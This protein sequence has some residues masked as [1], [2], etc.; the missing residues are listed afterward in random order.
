ME[1][2]ESDQYGLFS[3]AKVLGLT[4]KRAKTLPKRQPKLVIALASAIDAEHEKTLSLWHRTGTVILL[5]DDVPNELRICDY[6]LKPPFDAVF[7]LRIACALGSVPIGSV[8]ETSKERM[9]KACLR[10]LSMPEHLLGFSYLVHSVLFLFQRPKEQ[11]SSMMYEIYPHLASYFGTTPVMADRA[12]RHA[13]E[14]SWNRCDPSVVSE[15]LGYD[16]NDK[17]GIP[18]NA[19][20][21]YMLYERIRLL[22]GEEQNGSQ[23]TEEETLVLVIDG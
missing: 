5:I 11:R 12:I 2:M 7:L 13:V 4:A 6:R 1:G 17:K 20:Y 23:S 18:T 16:R 15:Y 9:A 3:A 14:V 19:E 8:R 10:S 22:L 21:L